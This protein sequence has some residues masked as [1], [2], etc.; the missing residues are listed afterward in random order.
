MT[1]YAWSRFPAEVNDHGQ[2]TKYIMPGEE[3]TKSKVGDDFDYLV[4]VGAIREEKYP[5]IADDTAPAEYFRSRMNELNNPV[6]PEEDM[7]E[8]QELA[9]IV[10]DSGTVS[11]ESVNEATTKASAGKQGAS[12]KVAA[13][14]AETTQ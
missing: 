8:L 5:D 1:Y 13:K 11:G 6:V 14:E 4:E 7:E 3:I 10:T 9:L 2:V 12:E